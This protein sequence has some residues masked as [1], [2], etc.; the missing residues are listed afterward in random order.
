MGFVPTLA[1]LVGLASSAED[2]KDICFAVEGGKQY[3][4]NSTQKKNGQWTPEI[5]KATGV[6]KSELVPLVDCN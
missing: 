4:I 5:Y 2:I 3:V 6:L 1:G